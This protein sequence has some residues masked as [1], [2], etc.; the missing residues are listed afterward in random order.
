VNTGPFF[1]Y[2][3]CQ[4]SY[5]GRAK[6]ELQEGNYIIIHKEDGTLLV[7]GNSLY[8]PLNFQQSGATLEITDNKI[9]S[10]R[11]K[12]TITISIKEI[13]HSYEINNWSDNK[14]ILTGT[15]NHLRQQIINNIA[16]YFTDISDI[17]IEYR[18]PFG[19]V[20]LLIITNGFYNI[21]ELKIRKAGLS[22][23][24]QLERYVGYFKSISQPCCGYLVCP[25]ITSNARKYL[26]EHG[27]K[28]LVIIHSSTS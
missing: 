1:L 17:Q 10:T 25:D 27:M 26:L 12:E 9:I 11:K 16:N 23:C 24:T 4:V 8:K 2:A 19:P 7:H 14:I 5:S 13:L 22:A 18:T 21:L 6:S 3:R 15:E 20:D 28:L